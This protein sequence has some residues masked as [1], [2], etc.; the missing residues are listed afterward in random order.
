MANYN[1]D[2]LEACKG[3]QI[4]KAKR[5]VQDHSVDVHVSDESAF[6][7]ACCNGHIEIVKWLVQDHQVDVHIWN[8]SAFQSACYNGCIEI[9]KW[10]VY[11]HQV[12]IH[13][14]NGWVFL[15]VCRERQIETINWLVEEYRY[16]ESPYYYHNK[17]AYILNHE[18]LNGWQTCTIQGCPVIYSG[19]LDEPAVIAYI[20]TLKRPKSARS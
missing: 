17:T 1:Q 4:E 3:G 5:L 15:W 10:L 19:E 8:E 11:N 9:A 14:D 18:P 6:R 20:E 16:S 13:A 7:R 2:F 12:D